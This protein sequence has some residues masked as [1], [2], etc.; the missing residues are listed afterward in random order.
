MPDFIVRKQVTKK[1]YEVISNLLTKVKREFLVQKALLFP[2]RPLDQINI[3]DEDQ[4][5]LELFQRYISKYRHKFE[6]KR[7]SWTELLTQ[8]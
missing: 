7:A 3:S 1:D 4:V 6:E 8:A 5:P 2:D